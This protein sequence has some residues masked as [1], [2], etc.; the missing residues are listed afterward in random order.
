MVG[1]VTSCFLV[2]IYSP[3]KCFNLSFESRYASFPNDDH[4][5][6]KILPLGLTLNSDS[7]F[8]GYH[9]TK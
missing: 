5:E 4:L 8:D 1:K 9:L 7:I 2:T 6:N 3:G